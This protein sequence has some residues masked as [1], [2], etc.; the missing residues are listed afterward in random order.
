MLKVIWEVAIKQPTI[1]YCSYFLIPAIQLLSP[2]QLVLQH[3]H[4]ITVI[5]TTVQQR[6]PKRDSLNVESN[7]SVEVVKN[8]TELEPTFKDSE[9]MPARQQIG[10]KYRRTS[11]GTQV[12]KQQRSIG[13]TPSL[14]PKSRSTLEFD[15]TRGGGLRFEAEDRYFLATKWG[16]EEAAESG[17]EEKETIW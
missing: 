10:E 1:Q 4:T 3:Y 14:D 12:E 16:G 13:K 5:V 11:V 17:I 7:V 15:N 8:A 6:K 2:S 9:T